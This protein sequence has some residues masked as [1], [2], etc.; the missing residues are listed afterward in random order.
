MAL[1]VDAPG[2]VPLAPPDLGADRGRVREA[3]DDAAD[4]AE[5]FEG[6]LVQQLWQIMR[7]TVKSGGMLGG[8]GAGN[9]LY[10]SMVDDAMGRQLTEGGGIGLRSVLM[11]AMGAEAEPGP[12]G[13]DGAAIR[14][15]DF[16]PVHRPAP[17]PRT[18]AVLDGATGRLQDVAREMLSPESAPRWGRDGRLTEQELSSQFSAEVPGGVARFNVRDSAGYQGYY[19]CNLFALEMARRAGFQVPLM[20]RT[21]GYSYPHPDRVAADAADGG[22]RAGWG[23]V[24]TGETVEQLNA[25][26]DSGDR[27]FMLTGSG[28]GDHAGHMG[29]VERVHEVHYDD[30]GE[31]ER[32][33]FD[34]WEARSNGAEH[35][36]RRTWNRYGNRG[37]GPARNG[38]DRIELIEL[39]PPESAEAQE[40]PLSRRAGPSVR[41]AGR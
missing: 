21:R 13:V 18:G 30:E 26:I 35:L 19:K 15:L 28:H 31:I 2:A 9:D 41:D 6:M 12:A 34:G 23:R 11:R 10:M 3:P 14:A 29:V 1:P 38:L 33:V 7:R 39:L 32:V 36:T 24:A 40:I 37:E 27:A 25:A 5:Q 17:G 8:E 16:A 22:L 4:V 20:A